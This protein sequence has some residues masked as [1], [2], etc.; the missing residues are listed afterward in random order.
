MTKRN[1]GAGT[2]LTDGE[3]N[4]LSESAVR[5]IISLAISKKV[6]VS[7]VL[8]GINDNT[9]TRQLEAVTSQTGGKIYSV[10]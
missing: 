4:E 10:P 1:W 9:A 5:G 6:S 8:V 3:D 2:G 7:I